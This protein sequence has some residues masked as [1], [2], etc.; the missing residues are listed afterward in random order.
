MGHPSF[1]AANHSAQRS[2]VASSS[3]RKPF[4]LLKLQEV[5][6]ALLVAHGSDRYRV[7]RLAGDA[8]CY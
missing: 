4:L 2:M 5:C 6:V 8:G 7:F 1:C 3:S